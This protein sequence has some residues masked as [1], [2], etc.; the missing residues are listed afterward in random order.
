LIDIL[1]VESVIP[2]AYR[3]LTHLSQLLDTNAVAFDYSRMYDLI[4]YEINVFVLI[5]QYKTVNVY[6]HICLEI[7]SIW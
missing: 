1:I 6:I 3:Y 4:R 5:H 7:S 2:Y